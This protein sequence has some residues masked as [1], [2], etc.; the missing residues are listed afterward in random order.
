MRTRRLTR[1]RVRW[2]W[3]AAR[4]GRFILVVSGLRVTVSSLLPGSGSLGLKD[5]RNSVTAANI[6]AFWVEALVVEDGVVGATFIQF[7][8]ATSSC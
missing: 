6:E 3:S 8:D 5:L 1:G 2:L 4:S 7:L